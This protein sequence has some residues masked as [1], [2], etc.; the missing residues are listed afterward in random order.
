MQRGSRL[1]AS[2]FAMALL[3]GS[4]TSADVVRD[5][6][7]GSAGPGAVA[8][9]NG[10]LRHLIRESD[11]ARS[12]NNLFHSFSRF[13]LTENE[14]A[15]YQ[16]DAG[17]R[18]LVTTVTGGRSSIDGAIESEIAGAN[19]FFINPAGVVFG[20]NATVD[21]SGAFS[22]STADRLHFANGDVLD[23][24]AGG[25]PG[26]LSVADPSGFGFLDAPAAIRVEGSRLR[27]AVDQS[28]AFI[29]GDID[30]VGERTDGGAGLIAAPSGRIDLASLAGAGVVRLEPDGIAIEGSP[31]LGDIT[32]ADEMIVSSSGIENDL[33]LDFQL[34]VAPGLGSGPIYIRADDLTIRDAELKTLTGTQQDASDISID[35]TGRLLIEGGTSPRQTGIFAG[36]GFRAAPAPGQTIL[37][38]LI[39]ALTGVGEIWGDFCATGLCGVRYFAEGDAGDV[40]IRAR[41]VALRSGGKITAAS[42]FSGDAGTID[43]EFI[44]E[45]SIVGR[46]GPGDVSLMT[47]NA[48]GTGNPG[49]I[50]IRSDEGLLRMDDFGGLV[51]QNGTRSNVAGAAGL[52]DIDVAEIE[53]SGNARIDSSTR[54]DGPGGVLDITARDRMTLRGR[55]DDESFTGISTLSQPGSRGP[56][57]Q[58][59]VATADLLMEDGAEISARPVGDTALGAAG[60]LSFE[61]GDRLTMRDAT[62]STKSANAAGGNIEMALG[63]VGYLV[64]SSIETS[65]TSGPES[66]G[67]ITIRPGPEALVLDRSQILARA[68]LGRGGNIDLETGVLIVDAASAIDASSALGI[69]GTVLINGVEGNIVPEVSQLETPAVDASGLVREPCAARLPGASNRFVIDERRNL[70][71]AA[72]DFLDVPL[73]SLLAAEAAVQGAA[74]A[75]VEP[76][77]AKHAARAAMPGRAG[78]SASGSATDGESAPATQLALEA[79][80]TASNCMF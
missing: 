4:P 60:S 15:V 73:A 61:I 6:R 44:D 46:R 58:V 14:S 75:G 30:L 32:I 80:P 71:I 13:D 65:V 20:E 28:L 64:R 2:G 16:G 59:R 53:M 8:T 34:G 62:I 5:G 29:G 11:G 19:L 39:N 66:G 48:N 55:T 70:S 77:T 79:G 52:I 50:R 54:G 76:G 51:I 12:G 33:E 45:I 27:M 41:D 7:I 67:N 63:G 23:A 25:P 74:P 40:R 35:L 18:N 38:T 9:E 43:I 69:D 72:D 31:R 17:I 10:G 22:V 26:I 78:G 68:D 24:G 47:T 37:F 42:E 21:I 36:T 3:S 57:G 56:A 49:T 1:A